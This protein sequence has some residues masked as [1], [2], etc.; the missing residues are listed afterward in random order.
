MPTPPTWQLPL[1]VDAALWDYVHDEALARRYDE[2]LRDSSLLACDLDFALAELAGPGRPVGRIVDLGCGTGRASLAFAARG[3]PVTAVDLSEPMLA[4]TAQKAAA[5]GVTIDCLRAN[6]AEL[7]QLPANSFTGAVC[8]FGT[9]GMLVGE[10]ARRRCLLGVQR[11]LVPGGRL[12]VHVHNRWHGLTQPGGRAWLAASLWRYL[13]RGEPLGDRICPAHQG[14]GRLRMHLFSRRSI[15]RLLRE[16]GLR[17][18]RLVPVG[19]RADGRLAWPWLAAS[20]R[21]QGYLVSAQR[22]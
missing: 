16:C 3:F 10:A 19:L 4:V 15:T 18:T 11:L 21:A 17:V 1:G 8:L 5:A 9:L 7:D 2:S 20:V 12:V 13:T 6:L 22:D 14:L